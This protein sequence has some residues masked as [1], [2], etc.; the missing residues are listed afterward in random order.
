MKKLFLLGGSGFIG[1]Y[2]TSYFLKKGWKVTL[3]IRNPNKLKELP[4]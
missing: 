1:K 3:L 2:L 4:S